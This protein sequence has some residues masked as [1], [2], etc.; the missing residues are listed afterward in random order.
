[1][2][3]RGFLIAM[4]TLAASGWLLRPSNQGQPHGDY[5]QTIN[6]Y[7]RRAGPGRPLMLID[8]QRL[9]ANCKTLMSMMPRHC[10]LRIVAKSLPSVPL[11]QEVMT[12]TG[13]RRIMVFHQP[14]MNA[15]AD[16][17]PGCDMLLGKPMPIRAARRFYSE[18][19][20]NEQSHPSPFK[21]DQ[22]LQWLIDSSSRL[23]QYLSLAREQ[24]RHLNIN[25]EIDVGLHR[26]GLTDPQQLD[27]MIALIEA[28]PEQLRFS[29]FMGYDA[30]V[31]RLPSFVQSAE[32][33]HRET[34]ALYQQYIHRLYHLNPTYRKQDLCFN[35]A[36]SPTLALYD[37]STVVNELSAGSCL[38]KA[39]D[40]DLPL[41]QRF[42]PA[43][44]IA[45]PVIKQLNGLALPGPLPLGELWQ[46][47]DTNRRQSY[48]IY[49]GYWKA[50]PISPPGIQ[51]N[52]LYGASSNQMMYNASED[53]ALQ[54]DDQLFLRPTQSEFVLLQ[55]GDLAVWENGAVSDWWPPLPQANGA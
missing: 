14:F 10:Q 52:P 45:A 16:A 2:K 13:S 42:Q 38:V 46:S 50:E 24:Q 15:L 28:H 30:H 34:E 5:F 41:L 23:E 37:D 6:D 20:H 44:F 11:I 33:G 4:A 9:A 48:F 26:G 43:A 25:I 47:W 36:G 32:E 39:S 17:E 35:G 8:R 53:T 55:F 1:M 27:A 7:L 21:P 3:R 31:G 29:G 54:V 49:G 18:L 12:H 40:F 22:Q 51:A 19:S